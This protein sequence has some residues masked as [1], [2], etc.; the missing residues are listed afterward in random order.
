MALTNQPYL[1]LYVD[2]WMNNNKLKLC[3][4]AAHGVMVSVMCIMHKESEYGRLLLKQKFKQTTKQPENFALQI[5]KQS[6]FDLYEILPGLEE[7]I[8]EKVLKIEGEYLVCTRMVEDAKI[9]LERSKSGF[10]G[11]KTTQFK[12]KKFAQAKTEANTVYVNEDENE[13]ESNNKKGA[14]K[15]IIPSIDQFKEYFKENDYSEELAERAWKGY[16]AA[17]WQ[18]SLGNKIKSWKQKCQ[19]VWFKPGNKEKPTTEKKSHVRQRY[20]E[21]EEIKQH[22]DQIYGDQ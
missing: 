21:G 19:H 22:N 2:D 10:K 5:A 7:L 11:G 4:P 1:P 16:D 6:S 8:S 15:F 3:S 18:D 12:S 14:K 17:G 20:D 9:S 13:D